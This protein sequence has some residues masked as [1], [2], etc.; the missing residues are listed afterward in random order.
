M[1]IEEVMMKM[2]KTVIMNKT[3]KIT[4]MMKIKIK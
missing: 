3:V 2:K 1:K 4:M